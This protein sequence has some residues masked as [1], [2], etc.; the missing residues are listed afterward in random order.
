[1][2]V[3]VGGWVCVWV[4]VWSGWVCVWVYLQIRA[5][6]PSAQPYPPSH[7]HTHTHTHPQVYEASTQKSF[8]NCKADMSDIGQEWKEV[9]DQ[10]RTKKER[11]TTQHVVGVGLTNVLKA[12]NYTLEE[13][14]GS[15][16]SRELGAS[17][18]GGATAVTTRQVAG[19]DYD[20]LDFCMLC[21]KGEADDKA[22]AAGKKKGKGK[23]KARCV[24]ACVCACARVCMCARECM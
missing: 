17:E 12:N 20:H 1:M 8:L 3:W 6:H 21:R 18:T 14:E 7:P 9:T 15:V 2:S 22:P 13:G 16:W 11:F 10:K 4:C 24:C 19:R 23:A 5:R